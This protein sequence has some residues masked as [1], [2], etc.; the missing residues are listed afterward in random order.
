MKR[1]AFIKSLGLSSLIISTYS[2][3]DLKQELPPLSPKHGGRSILPNTLK[4]GD[5]IL[6][7]TNKLVSKVISNQTDLPISHARIVYSTQKPDNP[8]MA[9]SVSAGVRIINYQEMMNEDILS[10]ALRKPT[11]P[12]AKAPELQEWLLSKLGSDYD[13]GGVFEEWLALKVKWKNIIRSVSLGSPKKFYCSELVA[14]AYKNI[15]LDLLKYAGKYPNRNSAPGR[16]VELIWFDELDY[17]GHLK[18]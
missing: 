9:E 8:E 13:Y 7:T 11:F 16:F 12:N 5:I 4:V 10:V 18:Y 14:E 2:F 6:S 3:L 1:R 15:G 17:V